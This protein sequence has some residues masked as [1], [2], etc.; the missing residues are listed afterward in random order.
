[1]RPVW[2][3]YLF[4]LARKAKTIGQLRH[5]AIRLFHPEGILSPV[6]RSTHDDHSV[7]YAPDANPHLWFCPDERSEEFKNCH[8]R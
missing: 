7:R 3:R 8:S 4:Q 1:M 6:A 2:S 5:E